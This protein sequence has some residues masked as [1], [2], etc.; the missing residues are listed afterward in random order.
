MNIYKKL[1]D[2][3]VR[4]QATQVKATGNNTFAKYTYLELS[5]F[6]PKI[7]EICAAVGICGVV[8]FGAETAT[9]TLIDTDDPAGTIEFT[10]PMSSAELK[11]C[12][13][14]QNLGAVQSYLRRY[15]WMAA[16]EIVEHD[17]LDST[18]GAEK[19]KKKQEAQQ[20]QQKQTGG[21]LPEP[22]PFDKLISGLDFFLADGKGHTVDTLTKWYMTGTAVQVKKTLTPEEVE[23][24]DSYF[25]QVA[26]ALG[27]K[28]KKPETADVF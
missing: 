5:D 20:T 15:L 24:A 19:E 23:K 12:H 22:T 2:A 8:R 14:V 18:H 13:P 21:S 17:A 4:L 27:E 9:L 10:S 28:T 16:F 26:K 11:G 6:L 3:R 25:K 7:N 1:Q